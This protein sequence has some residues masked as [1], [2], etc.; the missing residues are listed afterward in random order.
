MNQ[1]SERELEQWQRAWQADPGRIGPA[2]AELEQR[3][4]RGRRQLVLVIALEVVMVVAGMA[5][6]VIAMRRHADAPT[7]VWALAVVV[8]LALASAFAAWN[9][10]GLLRPGGETCREH[11]ALARARCARSMR[12]V[13]FGRWL[14]LV[15]VMFLVPWGCWEFVLKRAEITTHPWPYAV[16]WGLTLV[17]VIGVLTWARRTAARAQREHDAL[18]RLGE[19]L[20]E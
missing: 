1:A 6:V 16:R 7:L 10:R 20:A 19:Q 11:L 18:A 2:V 4:A 15:E 8:L 5:G 3:L 17:A 13:R 12:S 9:R 14:L